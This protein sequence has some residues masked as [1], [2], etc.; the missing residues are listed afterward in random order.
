MI[1]QDLPCASVW[2]GDLGS[3]PWLSSCSLLPLNSGDSDRN[4][5]KVREG[6]AASVS[7]TL[8]YFFTI[9]V[10]EG[11]V[12]LIVVTG[13]AKSLPSY[14]VNVSAACFAYNLNV[15]YHKA[16]FFFFSLAAF[17][18]ARKQFRIY[19]NIAI[20]NSLTRFLLDMCTGQLE[21]QLQFSW[22]PPC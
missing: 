20:E 17:A 8:C 19:P 11:C 10:A 1:L 16:L 13:D 4:G 21:I 3:Q 7:D 12:M 2:F 22:V 6:M 15:S 14:G 5:H 18:I 9:A